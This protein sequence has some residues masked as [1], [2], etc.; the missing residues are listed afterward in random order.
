MCRPRCKTAI[1]VYQTKFVKE[2]ITNNP[3]P[4]ATSIATHK[5][6][7]I[8]KATSWIMKLGSK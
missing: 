6:M 5:Y 7:K 1:L 2:P 8:Y 4:F 3:L